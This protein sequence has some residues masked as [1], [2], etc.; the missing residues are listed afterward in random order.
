MILC[1]DNVDNFVLDRKR[2]I[3]KVTNKKYYLNDECLYCKNPFMSSKKNGKYCSNACQMLLKQKDT[4]NK[5][6]K[7]NK[8]LSK[9]NI[10][11]LGK[12][13]STTSTIDV[14]CLK[15][16]NIWK[17]SYGNIKNGQTKCSVCDPWSNIPITWS[18][19]INLFSDYNYD[20]LTNKNDF[21][22]GYKTKLLVKCPEGHE[23][24][25]TYTFFKAGAK[26]CPECFNYKKIQFSDIKK[27]MEDEGWV[28][29]SHKSDY[30]NQ[31]TTPIY[32]KCPNGHIQYKSVR[33]WRMGRR[34]SICISSGPE[35]EIRDFIKKINIKCVFNT[36]KVLNGLELDFYFPDKKKA[37]EFNGDYW[38]SNYN[39]YNSDYYNKHKGLYASEIWVKD[40]IK[41]RKCKKY[42]IGLMI[43]WDNSWKNDSIN[44]KSRIVKFINN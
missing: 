39:I 20:V 4:S 36:R 19:V 11:L 1:W 37:I 16:G 17:N 24:Y 15:C 12:Y 44:E 5:V 30:K 8:S 31:N 22:G 26:K 25:T 6:N 21:D 34:C 14:M 10:K 3:N 43:I 13:K 40:A 27:S 33:K 42:G 7:I 38:H 2:F 9:H 41:K 18:D 28:V 23:R 35:L 32:C 29:L